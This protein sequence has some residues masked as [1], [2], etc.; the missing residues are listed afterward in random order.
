VVA[1][2]RDVFLDHERSVEAERL[3]CRYRPPVSRDA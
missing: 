3:C 2:R 1:T